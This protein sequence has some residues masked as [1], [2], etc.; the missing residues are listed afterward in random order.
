VAGQ[1]QFAILQTGTNWV[2]KGELD[3]STAP[4][5]AAAVS[6]E[7]DNGGNLLFDLSGVTF[8][9]SSGLGVLVDLSRQVSE[10][11]G[12]VQ[13]EDPSPSVTRLL[14]ITKMTDLFGVG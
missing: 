9:D 5:V 3:A 13:L 6:T 7:A 10:R 1:P 12:S 14:E 2:V 11:G 4:L 8:I